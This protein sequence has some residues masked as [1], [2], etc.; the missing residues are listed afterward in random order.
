MSKI[1]PKMII[2]LEI[3]AEIHDSVDITVGTYHDGN[4]INDDWA[5]EED[6]SL[7]CWRWDE[8]YATMVELVSIPMEHT[9]IRPVLQKLIREVF[10]NRKFSDVININRTCGSHIHISLVMPHK[11]N[12]K[13]HRMTFCEGGDV[14]DRGDYYCDCN[15][16]NDNDTI[17]IYNNRKMWA[18]AGKYQNIP[19]TEQARNNIRNAVYAFIPQPAKDNYFRGYAN[20]VRK[21]QIFQSSRDSEWT[22]VEG[23]HHYEYRSFNLR[24]IDNWESFV[25]AYEAAVNAIYYNLVLSPSRER[26]ATKIDLSELTP[27]IG[28]ITIEVDDCVNENDDPDISFVDR[29]YETY[30]EEEHNYEARQATRNN[31]ITLNWPNTSN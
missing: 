23:N 31:F 22:P 16:C 6:G 9:E 30:I 12:S 5:A 24:G 2:G 29:F 25:A 8:D 17:Q 7:D 14:Y 18:M 27:D 3:E 1:L 13:L 15:I 26:D 21:G 28:S 4:S 11:P 19:L 10:E 20:K